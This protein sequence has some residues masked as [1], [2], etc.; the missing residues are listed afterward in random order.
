MLC[1]CCQQHEATIHVT[2]V[3]GGKSREL[4]LCESCAEESGL[5][6]QNVMALPEVLF[7]MAGAAEEDQE[8]AA[9]SCPHC[10]MRGADFKK[11][12]RLGCPQCYRTFARELAPMLA[13]M[14]KGPRHV[15]KTPAHGGT[16]P[17]AAGEPLDALRRLLADAVRDERF[18]EA[19]RLRDRIREL[20]HDAG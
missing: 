13:A 4:H 12:G 6:V 19:A 9:R 3:S 17:E 14:H 2:Q 1:E 5:N 18:E 20:D 15:G 10:H 16:L 11:T 8:A 7:G